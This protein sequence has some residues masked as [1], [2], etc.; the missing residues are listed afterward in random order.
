VAKRIHEKPRR[1]WLS[2]AS[3][4]SQIA[5]VAVLACVIRLIVAVQV[6]TLPLSASPHYDSLEYL[7]WA[8]RIA[9]GD[10]SWPVAPPH[11]PGYPLF[12]GLILA[13]SRGSMLMIRIVQSGVGGLT[14]WLAGKTSSAFFGPQAGVATAAL[15]AICSPLIWIDV[16]IF[17]EGLFICFMTAVLYCTA[18]G[19][20]AVVIGLLIGIAALVRPT[21]LVLLP[22]LL[23]VNARPWRQR[24][25]MIGIVVL[26]SAPVTILNWRAT[27][28]FIPIQAFGGMNFYLGNSPFRDGVASARP[29]GDWDRIESEAIRRGAKSPADED[30]YFTQK[31]L[32]EIADHPFLYARLV[33]RKTIWTFQNE[34]IRDTHSFYFFRSLVPLLWLPSF[35]IILGLAVGGMFFISWTNRGSWVAAGYVVVIA[36]STI[37]LVV[38]SR[39]R[40]PVVVGVAILAG[41]GIACVLEERRTASF[42]RFI[43]ITACAIA[44]T[45]AWRHS[46]SHNFAEEY[47][48]TS[49][50]L[51]AEGSYSAAENSARTAVLQDG[52]S[53][54][55]FDSLGVSIAIQGRAQEATSVLERAVM[56]NPEFTAAHLHLGEVYESLR[57]YV[58]AA[59]EY[60]IAMTIDPRDSRAIQRLAAVKA[61]QGDLASAVELYRTIVAQNPDAGTMYVLARLQGAAGQSKAGFDTAR[62]AI[63]LR[64]PAA[65]EWVLIANLASDAGEFTTSEEAMARARLSGAPALEVML[66]TAMLRFRQGRFQE[67]KVIIDEILAQDPNSDQARQLRAAIAKQLR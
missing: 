63:A 20:N 59:S 27:H 65:D 34:E 56:L 36:A 44:A 52:N 22:L 26:V 29:G 15:L 30:R 13:I 62:R 32:S 8:H 46:P 43:V 50:S 5:I 57:D 24:A 21:A 35:G 1:N 12:L 67:S 14:C 33:V 23:L 48:L 9:A 4:D 41:S 47:A 66:A 16:S 10:F 6:N 17:A 61:R 38:G 18:T 42:V 25:L 49:Q 31:T 37:G 54:P 11:G 53:A 64:E 28:A 2:S 40:L 55:A 19:R 58:R 7:N 3:P 45:L 39:Y 51:V 60:Q